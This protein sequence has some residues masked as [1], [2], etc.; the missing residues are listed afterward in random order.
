MSGGSFNYLCYKMEEAADTLMRKDQP[1]YRKAFGVL[2]MRCAKAMHD[3]EWVDSS[4][5]SRGDDEEAIMK[6]I[7]HCDVLNMA[8]QDAEK[9]I[10][11]LQALLK[12]AKEK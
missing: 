6:C 8:V 12:Q 4:D 2:M 10:E 9:V 3:I 1:P 7:D 11:E 5:M